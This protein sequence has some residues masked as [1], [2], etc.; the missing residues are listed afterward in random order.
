MRKNSSTTILCDF[1]GTIT[2]LCLCDFLYEQF[3]SCS[4]KYSELWAQGKIGTREEIESSFRYIKA[5]REEMEQSLRTVPVTPGFKQF[6]DYCQIK[7]YHLVIV[8]DG[9]DWAIRFLLKQIGIE[10]IDVMS[11]QIVFEEDGPRF[12]FPYYNA[13]SP[14]VGVCKIDIALE[15]KQ[16]GQPVFLIGDGRTDLEA[17]QA[18]DFIFARDELWA[19]CQKSNLPSFYYDNF[20]DILKYLQNSNGQS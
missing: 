16:K 13:A 15:F 19:Y 2:R 4:M 8:S 12:N 18:V 9:L 7:D 11:N 1:D 20:F 10:D 17:A 5:S 3:A 14:K 6:Y